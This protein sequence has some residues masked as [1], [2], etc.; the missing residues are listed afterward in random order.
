MDRGGEGTFNTCEVTCFSPISALS[1]K[2]RRLSISETGPLVLQNISKPALWR[3][4]EGS[5]T[6]CT[7]KRLWPAPECQVCAGPVESPRAGAQKLHR[8]GTTTQ[9]S[10]RSAACYAETLCNCL[11]RS[12]ER[13]ELLSSDL[14][15][16]TDPVEGMTATEMQRARLYPLLSFPEQRPLSLLSTCCVQASA[17]AAS[18]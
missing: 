9:L 18:L 10:L 6:R 12:G 17:A 5:P 14:L 11:G 16:L 3:H 15:L 4:W 1:S 7:P 13:S 8:E 2:R